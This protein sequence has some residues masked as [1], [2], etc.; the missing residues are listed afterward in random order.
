MK[1]L[2]N[3]SSILCLYE[4]IKMHFVKGS[5]RI[6]SVSKQQKKV[7]SRKLE[8]KVLYFFRQCPLYCVFQQQTYKFKINNQLIQCNGK[9]QLQ[10]QLQ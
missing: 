10:T 2:A 6:I 4:S 3:K 7:Q 9:N 5:Y 1:A 8:W